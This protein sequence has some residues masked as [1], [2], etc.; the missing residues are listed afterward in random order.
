MEW[1]NTSEIVASA[2]DQ[3]GI[4]HSS[5][6]NY[7]KRLAIRAEKEIKSRQ[8]ISLFNDFQVK[9]YDGSLDLPKGFITIEKVLGYQSPNGD[10]ILPSVLPSSFY[11]CDKGSPNLGQRSTNPDK[12]GSKVLYPYAANSYGQG[13]DYFIQEY[14]PYTFSIQRNRIYFSDDCN[15]THADLSY[16]G[17]NVDDNGDLLV[18]ENHERAIEAYMLWMFKLEDNYATQGQ[19][20]MYAR[21]WA[22][23]KANVRGEDGLISAEEQEFGEKVLRSLISPKRMKF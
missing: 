14:Y 2:K 11:R 7:F 15:F 21:I 10:P 12:D 4:S 3:V 22:E 6:D 20:N 1:I 8:T 19:A 17:Y 18:P 16:K 9:V 13:G 23:Q 5:L